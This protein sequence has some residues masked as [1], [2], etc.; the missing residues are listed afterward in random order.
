DL[1]FNSGLVRA[2]E[3]VAPRGSL[4]NPEPGVSVGNRS[5]TQVR[6]LD[7]VT[8]ALAQARPDLVP[9]AGAGQASIMVVQLPDLE[10]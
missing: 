4:L 8:G 2:V 5:A 6:L 9:A 1:A 7:V 3:I 10:T